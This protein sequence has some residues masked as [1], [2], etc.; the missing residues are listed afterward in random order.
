MAALCRRPIFGTVAGMVDGAGEWRGSRR[1][2]RCAV[3]VNG[4]PKVAGWLRLGGHLVAVEK[5]SPVDGG[6]DLVV[7][8]V[9]GRFSELSLSQSQLKAAHIPDKDG[10][11]DSDEAL[12]G[13]WGRWMQY[14]SPRLRSAALATK[15]PNPYA[16]GRAPLQLLPVASMPTAAKTWQA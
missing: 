15:S 9:G 4:L 16:Q 13:L 10:K 3:P 14:A 2:R 6:F 7:R 1:A 11:G 12:A 5:V 8:D